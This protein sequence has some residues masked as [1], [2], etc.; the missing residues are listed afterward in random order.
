MKFLTIQK[1]AMAT[2]LFGG[3]AVAT[4]SFAASADDV[5]AAIAAAKAAQ[6]KAASVGGV[7]RDVGKFIKTAEKM[8]S[9][10]D[11]DKA[12]TLAN[13]AKFQSEAG[14]EQVM[15]ERETVK[16]FPSFME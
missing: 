10:G 6:K 3:V 11:F 4:P 1:L 16:G 9:G 8:A 2:V 7:W 12:M 13:Q 14:Y 5:S 15:H